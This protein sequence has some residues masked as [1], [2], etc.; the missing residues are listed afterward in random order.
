MS[1]GTQNLDLSTLYHAERGKRPA[2]TQTSVPKKPKQDRLRIVRDDDPA[3]L[4]DDLSNL[5]EKSSRSS[6]RLQADDLS[7]DRIIK[8]FGHKKE[9]EEKPLPPSEPGVDLS[10]LQPRD[11]DAAKMAAYVQNVSAL[12]RDHRKN[13]AG[14]S[15]HKAIA[16]PLAKTDL[17][18]IFQKDKVC[19]VARRHADEPAPEGDIDPA[20][21][22][23]QAAGSPSPAPK[24]PPALDKHLQYLVANWPQLPHNVQAAILN[25]IDAAVAP[26]DD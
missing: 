23:P 5:S 24:V 20:H 1:A 25:V 10:V 13:S 14:E 18:E 2:L 9:P 8:P 7:E 26:D 12:Q 11:F 19:V 15:P 21:L 22:L 6:R 3:S 17:Q 4:I 16:M